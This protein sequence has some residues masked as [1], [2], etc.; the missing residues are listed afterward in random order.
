M[1]ALPVSALP[2]ASATIRALSGYERLFLAVD[3]VNG[4]NFAIAVTFSGVI[5]HSRWHAAFAQLQ[6]R[7]PLLNAAV[8]VDDWH[9]SAFEHGA[10]DPIPLTFLRRTSSAD[11]QQVMESEIAEPF[12]LS[13]A[14]LLRAAI[15]EDDAGCDLV[16]TANHVIADGISVLALVDELLRALAGHSLEELPPPQSAEGCVAA[17]VASDSGLALN[18]AAIDEFAPAPT[19]RTYASRHRKGKCTISALRLSPAQSARLLDCAR[20][21]QTTIG[22]VLLA[23]LAFAMRNV[24]PDQSGADLQWSTP[25]NARPYLGNEGDL[26]ISVISARG[27]DP[28][29]GD[30]LFA[31]ARAVKSSISKFQNFRAIQATYTR[32]DAIYAQKLDAATLVKAV[33]SIAGHD[34]MLSNLKTA[35]FPVVP[36]GLRVES[37][38]GP[39]VLLGVEG[40]QMIGSVTFGGALHLLYSSFTPLPGL[41]EAVRETIESACCTS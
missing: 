39:S 16:I 20:Q 15:V 19:P 6:K 26:A 1:T 25:V 24:S 18:A 14:P 27:I 13:V 29:P 41:L 12:D 2:R 23:A 31:A 9:A 8:N 11:W 32:V 34:L 3:I 35:E 38:W 5:A 17:I 36:E 33:V 10:G 4:F 7:H 22:A 28:H 21:N 37:V 40:E 30:D